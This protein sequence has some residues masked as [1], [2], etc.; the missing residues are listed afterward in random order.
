MGGRKR[1]TARATRGPAQ[2]SLELGARTPTR[3]M[4]VIAQDPSVRRAGRIVT[5]Q[6]AVPA[7][8]LGPGPMGYRVQVVDYDATRRDFHGSHVLPAARSAEPRSWQRG[9]PSMARSLRFHAQNVYALVM[10][11]LARFEFA[12]GR[13]VQ[14]S[15]QNHQLKIAPHGM[16]DANA[17]YSPDAEGLVFGYFEGA[18]GD[19]VHTCLSHDIVVHE[20]THALLDALRE[21]FM[22]PSTPDQAAFHE[23]F[24]DVVALLSVF[25]QPEVVEHL[26]L[27]GKAHSAKVA[28]VSRKDVEPKALR[29]S[30]LFGLAEQMGSELEGVRGQPLRQSAVLEP[31]P[32]LKDTPEFLEEH[33]RGELFVAAV[34]QGFVRAWSRRIVESGTPGQARFPLRRVAEEGA[35]IADTLVTMW[36]RAIDYMPPVHLEFGDALSAALTAD[37]EVRPDDSRY[38]LRGAMLESFESF[39][40]VPASSRREPRGIWFPPP[41]GL[42]YDRVRFESMRTDKDEMFRFIWENRGLLELRDGAY[43][44]VLSVRPTVRTGIDGFVLHETVAEYYQVAR[45]TPSELAAVGVKAPRDYLR[46]L[47]RQAAGR[48]GVA[49]NGDVHEGAPAA[50]DED[51]EARD[52]TTP[53]YGGGVL[54][55]DEYG[56]VKYWVHNDVFGRWQSR[57]LAY[58]WEQG[59]LQPGRGG[60][61]LRGA[62]LSSIH[63]LRALGARTSQSDRW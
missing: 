12:L 17:F 21:R 8:E 31:N 4:T 11:T 6:V 24:A 29:R 3:S 19:R 56:R 44:E 62:R 33:N 58:L 43:T 53:L 34:L 39:G 13:R 2:G 15:F 30:T 45:L 16:A 49:L 32:A 27:G 60:A 42:K 59:V 22:D 63:R 57:R 23:G 51:D 52:N 18:S 55:F 40:F 9:E 37:L 41:A 38:N 50:A 48:S 5:A 14:W 46:S 36:I 28:F 54:I 10:K 35:D 25:A 1:R 61:R 26:L 7:E 20:T 47:A